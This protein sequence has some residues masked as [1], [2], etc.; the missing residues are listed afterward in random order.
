MRKAKLQ[1]FERVSGD[2]RS[3]PSK[4]WRELGRLLGGGQRLVTELKTAETVLTDQESIADEFSKYFS[5][6]SGVLNEDVDERVGR[7]PE[8]DHEFH[9]KR[10]EEDEVLR[11]LRGLD[12][13]KA[14]GVDAIGAKLLKTAASGIGAGLTTLFNHCLERGQIP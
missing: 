1:F 2:A 6:L 12:V 8:C 3:N 11:L 10:V 13:N 9:F 5:T 4:A 14:V 7:L